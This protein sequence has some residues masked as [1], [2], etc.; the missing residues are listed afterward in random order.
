MYKTN[1]MFELLN[2]PDQSSSL[3]LSFCSVQKPS[4][5]SGYRHITMRSAQ[6]YQTVSQVSPTQT[7]TTKCHANSIFQINVQFQAPVLLMLLPRPQLVLI[8]PPQTLLTDLSLPPTVP[9]LSQLSLAIFCTSS[10]CVHSKHA[11]KHTDPIC[12]IKNCLSFCS[13]V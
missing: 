13:C 1:L 8:F 6:C 11:S 12:Q 2:L 7:C 3:N 9:D 5:A 10:L 4:S